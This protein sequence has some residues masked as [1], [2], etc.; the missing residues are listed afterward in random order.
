MS[1]EGNLV[2]LRPVNEKDL[3]K[4]IEWDENKEISRWVGKKFSC[5]A[6]AREWYLGTRRV[7]RKTFA[8]ETHGGK[9]IGEI[10]VL[11]ISW[12]LHTG[13]MRVFIGDK[14]YWD[15]GFGTDA[16][17]TFVKG[18][19]G[20]SALEKIFLRVDEDNFRARRCYQ[21]VGFKAVGRIRFSSKRSVPSK[22]LLMEIT[23]RDIP[24]SIERQV[25]RSGHGRAGSA[26]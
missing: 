22:L 6:E 10:E 23:T 7:D 19:F 25:R 24:S 20:N 26:E 15:K 2:R 4:L 14:N 11:N 21:K 18:L 16:V 9:L 1:F 17:Y 12:R 8:I 13:E 3:P 5:R